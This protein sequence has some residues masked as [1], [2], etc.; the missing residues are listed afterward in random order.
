[1]KWLKYLLMFMMFVFDFIVFG[2]AIL[3]FFTIGK[4]IGGFLFSCALTY[5][6]YRAWM[7]TGGW[8]H[9]KKAKRKQFY[10][11][12]DNLIEKGCF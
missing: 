6:A 12:W 8:M 2:V 7:R 9:W 11:S 1:M 10:K 5:L 3:L 4:S